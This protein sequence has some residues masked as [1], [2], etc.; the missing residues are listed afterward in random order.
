MTMFWP[1]LYRFKC[2]RPQSSI[3]KP[4]L[5]MPQS[6][7]RGEMAGVRTVSARGINIYLTQYTS[8]M[9]MHEK[10]ISSLMD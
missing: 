5:R 1:L 10:Q 8:L 4:G 9:T 6:Q 7:S 3:W 2:Q